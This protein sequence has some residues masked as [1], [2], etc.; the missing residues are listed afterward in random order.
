[1]LAF[2]NV[3]YI[4]G[5]KA[6]DD[7][8]SEIDEIQPNKSYSGSF[9]YNWGFT[10]L[11]PDDLKW[12]DNF[13]GDY[14]DKIAWYSAVLR[15]FRFQHR[16]SKGLGISEIQYYAELWNDLIIHCIGTQ[17]HPFQSEM[18]FQLSSKTIKSYPDKTY[19]KIDVAVLLNVERVPED[20]LFPILFAE[21]AADP[22]DSEQFH[23]GFRKMVIDMATVLLA[24]IGILRKAGK[25]L[26]SS[27]KM[28]S[29]FLS[30]I[31]AF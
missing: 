17:F 28:F 19:H 18:E 6:I 7:G 26:L 31:R 29:L 4:Q 12:N 11:P 8:L 9:E 30:I 27:L 24:Q 25:P 10:K 21:V 1:M 22:V 23:K 3:I 16:L 14:N 5:L 15:L 13:G 2:S 20:T